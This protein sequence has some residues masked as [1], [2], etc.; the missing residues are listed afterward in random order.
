MEKKLLKAALI[1]ALLSS[2]LVGTMLANL[3]RANPYI[4]GGN[5]PPP[6]DIQPPSISIF[7]PNNNTVFTSNNVTLTFN[8]TTSE[9]TYKLSAV[10]FKVD[11]QE[12]NTSV[13]YFLVNPDYLYIK[14]LTGIPEGKHVVTVTA[15]AHGYYIEG[16]T[17]YSYDISGSSSVYFSI[18]KYSIGK[19]FPATPVAAASVATAVVVGA[20]LLV[21]FK[22]R[23]GWRL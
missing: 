3:G 16:Y 14:N 21:Y 12:G 13:Y 22:K 1:S 9:E 23:K 17:S 8:V 11:W 5:T 18:E 4:K 20:G 7:S 2:V 19:P 15:V 10:Y 6:E